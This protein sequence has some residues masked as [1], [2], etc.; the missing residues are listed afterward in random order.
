MFFLEAPQHLHAA[1]TNMRENAPLSWSF[2]KR[3]LD[4]VIPRMEAY[5]AGANKLIKPVEP[6]RAAERG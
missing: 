4:A 2:V 3:A 1:A 6:R 5:L